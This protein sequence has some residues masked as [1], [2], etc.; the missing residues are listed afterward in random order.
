MKSL[1]ISILVLF[2]SLISLCHSSNALNLSYLKSYSIS[3]APNYQLSAPST[4][5]TSLTDGKYQL[6][7]FLD[8]ENHNWMA[9]YKK[10]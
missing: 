10:R 4:D 9:I 1:E 7:F 8:P 3:P 6:W 2:Y 5:K